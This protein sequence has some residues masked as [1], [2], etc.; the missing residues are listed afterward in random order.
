MSVVWTKMVNGCCMCAFKCLAF[1]LI[2][3]LFTISKHHHFLPTIGTNFCCWTFLCLLQLFSCIFIIL[4]KFLLL[5]LLYIGSTT[6]EFYVVIIGLFFSSCMCVEFILK[7]YFSWCLDFE[8][9]NSC[10][11][12][13]WSLICTYYCYVWLC[14]VLCLKKFKKET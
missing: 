1:C 13:S 12:G 11:N 8:A 5:I 10:K 2:P 4:V 9:S 14:F 7:C 3:A 6:A